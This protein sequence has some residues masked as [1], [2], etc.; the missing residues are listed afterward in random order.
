MFKNSLVVLAESPVSSTSGSKQTSH[1]RELF[2]VKTDFTCSWTRCYG[3]LT[4]CQQRRVVWGVNSQE[5]VHHDNNALEGMMSFDV[6]CSRRRAF[7]W[8][9]SWV[10]L[11]TADAVWARLSISMCLRQNGW[12]NCSTFLKFFPFDAIGTPYP[13]SST[14][15]C[16][17]QLCL[18]SVLTYGMPLMSGAGFWKPKLG[19]DNSVRLGFRRNLD[20][21]SFSFFFFS[22]CFFPLV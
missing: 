11:I 14:I 15:L 8:R 6:H 5:Q 3:I 9:L 18:R 19:Q 13:Y 2:R 7:M 4:S 21:W 22:L 17:L 16:T 20:T 10:W 1:A 12:E